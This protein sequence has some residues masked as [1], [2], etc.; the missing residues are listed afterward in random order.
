MNITANL[1]AYDELADFIAAL[2]QS[3]DDTH[4]LKN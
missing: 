1:L 3:I 2:V 4:S